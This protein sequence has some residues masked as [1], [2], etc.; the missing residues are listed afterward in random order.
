[1][2]SFWTA[3]LARKTLNWCVF[4]KIPLQLVR[5]GLHN[6]HFHP[7]WYE[8]FFQGTHTKVREASASY[9]E[10]LHA[11]NIKN[12]DA[13]IQF[14]TYDNYIWGFFSRLCCSEALCLGGEIVP[15]GLWGG[16]LMMTILVYW[17]VILETKSV[18]STW[19]HIVIR[20]VEMYR[21][22]SMNFMA[23]LI[24]IAFMPA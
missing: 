18:Q 19:P 20:C 7:V 15:V 22:P 9:F 11:Y 13:R 1:V 10:A 8:M 23:W 14:I 6:T 2:P 24:T 4:A 3:C 12:N 17:R 5:Q 21:K 16:W